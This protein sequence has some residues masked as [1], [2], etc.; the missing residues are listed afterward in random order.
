[1][2]NLLSKMRSGMC[3]SSAAVTVANPLDALPDFANFNYEIAVKPASS[4]KLRAWSKLEE[5]ERR[6][7]VYEWTE[8]LVDPLSTQ[9]RHRILLDDTMVAF[10]LSFETTIQLLKDQHKGSNSSFWVWLDNQSAYDVQVRGMRTLRH[11]EAHVE[12]KGISKH[13]RAT[14]H[15]VVGVAVGLES[16]K[17][18]KHK[19]TKDSPADGMSW[20]S[21]RWQLP[22]LQTGDL[23]KLR[24][25]PMI[26][27]ELP[28]WNALVTSTDAS[29]ILRNTLEKLKGILLVAENDNAF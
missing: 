20:M 21:G 9:K 26:E 6:L 10:I 22:Q 8:L 29:K 7:K 28:Q 5:C 23:A 27:Q 3:G 4:S 1:V 16:N 13:V 17:T 19:G 14:A 25:P 2:K 15:V 11:L 18:A 12:H 24:R